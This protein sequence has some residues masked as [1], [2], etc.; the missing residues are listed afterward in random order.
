MD[1][2]PAIATQH[3]SPPAA[4]ASPSSSSSHSPIAKP[5]SAL[6][7]TA[8]SAASVFSALFSSSNSPIQ[9]PPAAALSNAKLVSRRQSLNLP[10]SSSRN[11]SIS[12]TA[13][14]TKNL[15]AFAFNALGT[16]TD[17]SAASHSNNPRS[18]TAQSNSS[19]TNLLAPPTQADQSLSPQSSRS[20]LRRG[21]AATVGSASGFVVSLPNADTTTT[22]T[23]LSGS[24]HHKR[25]Q[26]SVHLGGPVTFAF[27]SQP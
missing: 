16:F 11:R 23:P 14:Q 17:S 21:S 7:T 4:V 2:S 6:T 8:T 13:S 26:Q 19:F 3:P 15:L 5:A 20:S 1:S 9:A 10:L 12:Y 18:I 22:E 27:A 25:H 24:S